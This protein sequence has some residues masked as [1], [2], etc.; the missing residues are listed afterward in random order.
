M[1]DTSHRLPE[2]AFKKLIVLA[3][4]KRGS[5][6]WEYAVEAVTEDQGVVQLRY[7]TAKK[8]SDTAT[9]ACPLIV[10]IPRDE[11]RAI[12]FIENKKPVTTLERPADDEAPAPPTDQPPPMVH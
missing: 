8:P 2:D 9:F 7:K 11:Y 4:I 12:E 10:S 5:S 3:A 6:F 1:N